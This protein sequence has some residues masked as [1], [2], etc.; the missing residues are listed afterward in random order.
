MVEGYLDFLAPFQ[1]G[2]KNIVASLGTALTQEQAR[3]LKRYTHNIVMIYDPDDAGQ[4]ATLRTLDVFIE[5]EMDVRVVSLPK[6]FDPDLFV[7]QEGIEAFKEKVKNAQGLFDYKLEALKSRFDIKEAQGKAKI[8]SEMLPT[9]NRFKNAILKAEYIKLLSAELNVE[10]QYVLQELKKIK[11]ERAYLD[12]SQS[13][14]RK[15]ANINPTEKLL[16]KMMLDETDTISRVK[17]ML[18]P[19]DFKG[20]ITSKIVSLM[21]DLASQGKSIEPSHLINYFGEEDISRLISESTLTPEISSEN[22]ERVIDD[23]IIRLKSDR[24]KVRK[25]HLQEEITTAQRLG[26]DEKLHLLIEE[27]NNLTKMR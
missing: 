6:G 17:E 1:D 10:E 8:A 14:P 19:D 11:G 16:I 26:N 22:K 18:Q 3:L 13:A 23:C 5:E 12:I 27:F 25:Q 20:E 2:V 15:L 9:I 24:L 7:R 21:F 4:I